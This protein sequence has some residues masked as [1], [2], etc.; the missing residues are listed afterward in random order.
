MT[1]HLTRERMI[2]ELTDYHVAAFLEDPN[3]AREEF[4]SSV[5]RS[6]LKGYENYTND[7]LLK[8]FNEG[9]NNMGDEVLLE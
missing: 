3:Y 8:A 6:G 2:Q 5:M 1:L 9:P 4:L 7:E